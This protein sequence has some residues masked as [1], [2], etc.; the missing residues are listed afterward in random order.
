[1]KGLSQPASFSLPY[2]Y[3]AVAVAFPML[4]QLLLNQH[5]VSVHGHDLYTEL[6]KTVAPTRT[7]QEVYFAPTK[8]IPMTVDS[9]KGSF[10][11]IPLFI[12][13]AFFAVAVFLGETSG[14]F[15]S[16][17]IPP[18]RDDQYH[19]NEDGECVMIRVANRQFTD[20]YSSE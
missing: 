14:Y 3:P 16:P 12:V 15:N 7:T 17:K 11:I 5:P 4:S 10:S 9:T 19:S 20:S 1:M 13:F 6:A 8:T 2:I 18:R